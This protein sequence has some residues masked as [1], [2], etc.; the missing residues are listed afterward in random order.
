MKRERSRTHVIVAEPLIEHIG[1]AAIVVF[2]GFLEVNQCFLEIF[3]FE[4]NI[5]DLEGQVSV[6]IQV[7]LVKV[8]RDAV[9]H[10]SSPA[11]RGNPRRKS[12]SS[13]LLQVITWSLISSRKRK[14]SSGSQ[15]L[16]LCGDGSTEGIG[17]G[18]RREEKRREEE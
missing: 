2:E 17:I 18:K 6:R 12:F 11:S 10:T 14:K 5:G 16:S 3:Q 1:R 4:V 13:F 9:L 8:M 15:S 7:D